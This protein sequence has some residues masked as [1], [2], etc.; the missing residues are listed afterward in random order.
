MVPG[1][2]MTFSSYPAMM[3]SMDDFYQISSGLVVTETT[4]V[5]NNHTLWRELTS[6]A[7]FDWVRNMLANRLAASGAEWA[8]W[9]AKYNSGTYNNE[10]MIVDYNKF[11]PHAPLQPGLLTVLEQMPGENNVVWEDLT[12]WL[13]APGY[14][15]SYNRPFFPAIQRLSEQQKMID[16][17]G[18]HFSWYNTS[19]AVLF[20]AHQAQVVDEA[21]Y[22]ALMRWNHFETDAIATQG[23]KHGRSASNAIS[24]RGDLTQRAAGCFDDIGPQDEVGTDC[25][26]TTY[27]LMKEGRYAAWAQSG[28]TY[29]TQPPFVWSQSPYKHVAHVGQPDK[30]AFPWVLVDWSGDEDGK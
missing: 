19:R 16:K 10:F 12:T 28:P 25:K 30:W 22:R 21:S 8:Q 23:C 18:D 11:V 4:I 26:Y 27:A 3:F 1:R 20:R 14:W 15:A 24:E 13:D 9:F 2:V 7:L 6:Q 29:D 5:N 17:Y